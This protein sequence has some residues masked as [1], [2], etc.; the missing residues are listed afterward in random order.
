MRIL[1]V[2]TVRDEGPFLLEWLAHHRAAGVTDVLAFS[3]DCRDGTDAMLDR[4][5]AMGWVVHV[6]NDGPHARGPQWA[7]LAAA[8]RHPLRQ[9]A[10]WAIALDIDEF[11]NV[12]VGD[13]T[14]PALIAALPG[15]TAVVLTWRMFGNAGEVGIEDIPVTR[16]FLRAAPRVLHWP[17]R[18]QQIKTLF[19]T[20]GAFAR[21]G[22][23]RPKAPDAARLA[24]EVWFDGAGR[25]LPP[26]FVTGPSFTPPGSDP[27]ALAQL[28]HYALGS[29]QDH[30]VKCDR[31][32]ANRDAPA[33][34]LGYWVD[35][36][37]CDVPDAS[38]LPLAD[39]AAPLLAELRADPVLG[40][41]HAAALAWRRAR[42]AALMAGGEDWRAHFGRLV[43]TP[44]TRAL[45]LAEA[46]E[47][48]RRRGAASAEPDAASG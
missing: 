41:L 5:A 19:A 13:R 9:A 23:H 33:F 32:R 38:I 18:A 43:M 7:A 25:R 6:R 39:R 45:T 10:D 12:A 3:N 31:G 2:L 1:A 11:V 34:D 48:W 15:A 46:R 14:I 26:A 29:M 37:F 24:A 47:I 36:N 8:S 4:L 42:F 44:P 40:R 22:V 35:R 17:W 16:R 27:Y 21:F 28:N 20:R 30:L